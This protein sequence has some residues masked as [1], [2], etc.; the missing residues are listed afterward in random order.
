MTT[1]HEA[2]ADAAP[3]SVPDTV[4]ALP[5]PWQQRTLATVN[6]SVVRVARLEGAFP[7]HHH[8]EDE[9]FL[10]WDGTFRIELEGRAPV[11][12]RAGELFVVPRGLRHRPVADEPAHTLLFEHPETKQYGN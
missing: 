7:W 5:G 6:E 12:L 11:T 8:D 3:V 1:H 9:M 2:P 4:A 10:C